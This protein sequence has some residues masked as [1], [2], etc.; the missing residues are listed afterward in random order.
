MSK[1]CEDCKTKKILTVTPYKDDEGLSSKF[2]IDPCTANS[3]NVTY[4]RL[5]FCIKKY[6]KNIRDKIAAAAVKEGD[7]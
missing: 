4:E 6:H 7:K 1:A 5:T 2:Y 3:V